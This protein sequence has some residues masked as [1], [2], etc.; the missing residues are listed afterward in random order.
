MKLV[1]YVDLELFY[2]LWIIMQFIFN[3]NLYCDEHPKSTSALP[4]KLTR[5][6]CSPVIMSQFERKK[7]VCI[8]SICDTYVNRPMSPWNLSH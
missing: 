1:L 2:S 3:M 6:T 8:A 7:N 4:W 5:S